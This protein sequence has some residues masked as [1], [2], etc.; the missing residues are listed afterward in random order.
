M[1]RCLRRSE[2]MEVTAAFHRD[3]P[4]GSLA[5]PLRRRSRGIETSTDHFRRLGAFRRLRRHAKGFRQPAAFCHGG[6]RT[7]SEASAGNDENR[8]RNR[9]WRLRARRRDIDRG[10]WTPSGMTK[11]VGGRA[12]PPASSSGRFRRP[13]P[14]PDVRSAEGPR[15]QCRSPA[16]SHSRSAR[17]ELR[18]YQRAE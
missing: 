2:P 5:A 17:R 18:R 1:R 14:S 9:D 3:E 4:P 8:A 12:R 16:R 7:T 13:R 15:A 10:G 6:R 11:S